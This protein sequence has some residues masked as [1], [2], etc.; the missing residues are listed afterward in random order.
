MEFDTEDHVLFLPCSCYFSG[1]CFS[2]LVIFLFL[3]WFLVRFPF[4]F[5]IFDGFKPSYSYC[6]FGFYLSCFFFFC[7]LISCLFL[8]SIV[9]SSLL[10]YSL[11]DNML[12]LPI[13][14]FLIFVTYLVNQIEFWQVIATPMFSFIEIRSSL[15]RKPRF[16][17]SCD[18]RRHPGQ[19]EK[20]GS[21]QQACG[22][23]EEISSH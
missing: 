12:Y 21:H 10:V 14:H 22:Q 13:F 17:C 20:R 4:L 18:V 1:A 5:V 15:D 23:G 11:F 7:L 9:V 16:S 2:C 3:F 8:H 19:E 6:D